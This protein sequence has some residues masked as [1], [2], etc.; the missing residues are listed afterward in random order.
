[1]NPLYQ[2]LVGN[3]SQ[4]NNLIQR[5]NQF[6]TGFN[7][8]A[9]AQ[10]QQLLNSGKISQQQYSQAQALASQLKNILK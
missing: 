1:M 7:G 4:M 2:Q 5:W 9:K 3:N 10:V 8:D 6:K